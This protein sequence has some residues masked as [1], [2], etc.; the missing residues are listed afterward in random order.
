MANYCLINI[1]VQQMQ[2]IICGVIYF[3]ITETNSWLRYASW[4]V[5]KPSDLVMISNLVNH[6]IRPYLIQE[7]SERLERQ[8]LIKSRVVFN[9]VAKIFFPYKFWQ[10]YQ[11]FSIFQ[12]VV[13]VCCLYCSDYKFNNRKVFCYFV[14]CSK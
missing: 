8:N 12:V 4:S 11:Y 2:Q 13:V 10:L 9:K 5:S 14:F 6:I 3:H 7:N 1:Q